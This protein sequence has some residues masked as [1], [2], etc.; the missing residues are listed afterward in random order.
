MSFLQIKVL[1][2]RFMKGG[3]GS[4][5][6]ESVSVPEGVSIPAVPASEGEARPAGRPAKDNSLSSAGFYVFFAGIALMPLFFIPFSGIGLEGVK[7]F[8]FFA[9]VVVS[10]FLWLI[11][12][13]RAGVFV[14]PKNILLG[15]MG[16]SVLTFC[17]SALFSPAIATSLHG[18]AYE[19]GTVASMLFLFLAMFL[20]AIFFQ[21]QKRTFYFLGAIAASFGIIFL[22]QLVRL[23]FGADAFSL[24]VFFSQTDNMVGKWNDLG[25]F[26][27][28]VS[29][30]SLL[31]L[32]FLSSPKKTRILLYVLLALSLALTALVDF[33]LPWLLLGIFSVV[34]LVY[35]LV[36]KGLGT[37]LGV[38]RTLSPVLIF[39]LLISFIFVIAGRPIGTFIAEKA[40]LSQVEVR[41]SWGSTVQVVKSTWGEDLFLG[42]GPNRFVNQWLSFKPDAVNDSLFWNTDFRSGVG[43]LPTFAV[44]TGLLGTVT[45]LAFLALLFYRGTKAILMPAE[46]FV[47]YL[48]ITSFFVTL[49]LWIVA[50][51]YLPSV[52]LVVLTFVM[53]GIFIA[54]LTQKGSVRNYVFSYVQDPKIGF[55]AVLSSIVV[56]IAAAMGGYDTVKS[57]ISLS[58]YNTS[59]SVFVDHGDADRA[60]DNIVRAINLNN[61]ETFQRALSEIEVA[62]LG[63]VIGNQKGESADTLRARFQEILGSAI[64][65]G[66]AAVALDKTNYANWIALAK[67][68]GAVAPLNIP[69]AYENALMSLENARVLNPKSPALVLERARLEA[70]RGDSKSARSFAGEAI[71]MKNNYTD[72]LFFL[73]Q[74]DVA[75]GN[76]KGAITSVETATLLDPNNP[77]LFFQL[78]LLKYENDDFVGAISALERAVLLR[79]DYSNAKYYLGLSYFEEGKRADAIGQF[80]DLVVANPQNEEIKTILRNLREGKGPFAKNRKASLEDLQTLPLE[81]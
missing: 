20:S 79:S 72:A 63:D 77:A 52:A 28:M 60:R 81:E 44:T 39:V 62:R 47:Q 57:F 25:I 24:G 54:T 23:F 73:A 59:R 36:F 14:I 35:N 67:V 53:T 42:S 50:L 48:A 33:Y 18:L 31:S 32:E 65:A 46:P 2:E 69:G 45:L 34:L 11:G 9:I 40:Q 4:Y 55:A 6:E 38:G 1:R 74:L 58:Y 26:A 30:V 75:E 56:L 64:G 49:Y 8:F 80:E 29:L 5:L 37:S 76:I 3:A 21:S 51:F 7:T 15:L 19:V 43:L 66:Q 13:L 70:G 41:P 16:V 71:G 68:Y 12:E 27:G 10:L 17:I 61:A 78:G 22:V